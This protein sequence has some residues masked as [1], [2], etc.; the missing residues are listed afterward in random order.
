MATYTVCYRAGTQR[1]VG[2]ILYSYVP[3]FQTH[4]G[5]KEH[6]TTS[7]GLQVNLFA[8]HSRP[9]LGPSLK[10]KGKKINYICSNRLF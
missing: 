4:Q 7:P 8:Q 9:K 2:L 1:S 3:Q 6:E 10:S 5:K